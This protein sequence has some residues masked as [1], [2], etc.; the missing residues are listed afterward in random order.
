MDQDLYIHRKFI[1]SQARFYGILD[2]GYVALG[3][4]DRVASL[5]IDGGVQ[6]IQLRAKAQSDRE[7]F[8]LADRLR[9]LFFGVDVLFII[10]DHAQVAADMGADGV[11]LGQEDQSVPDVRAILSGDQLVGLST[12][13]LEQALAAVGQGPDYIGLGPIFATP[14][15]PDYVPVGPELIRQVR[16]QVTLPQ[17]CIGGVKLENIPELLNRGAERVVIVSGIL[18]APDIVSY[19]RSVKNL[20]MTKGLL[21]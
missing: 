5:M 16:N 17:F 18:Q 19:C 15:K 20:M 6:I 12:H 10:N 1:L 14:T 9:K 2:T 21:V 11:H 4:L 8:G 13:S 3:D 7:V